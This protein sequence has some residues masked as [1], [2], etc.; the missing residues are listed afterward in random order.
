MC[1]VEYFGHPWEFGPRK[2]KELLLTGDSL[3]VHEAHQLGMVSKV[4]PVAELADQTLAFARRIAR[5]T[6]VA[7]LLIK[8]SVNQTVDHMGFYNATGLRSIPAITRSA[9]PSSGWCRGTRRPPSCPPGRR[10]L[11]DQAGPFLGDHRTSYRCSAS[12]RVV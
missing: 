10:R 6:T 11:A 2:A 7:A 1:G 12:V 4:F 9:R 5:T 8:E 3:D